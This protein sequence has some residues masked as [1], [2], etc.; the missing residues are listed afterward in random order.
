MSISTASPARRWLPTFPARATRDPIG[1]EIA[2]NMLRIAR[3]ERR[4]AHVAWTMREVALKPE[5]LDASPAA[6]HRLHGIAR[7]HALPRGHAVATLA[8]PVVDVFPIMLSRDD[9]TPLDLQVVNHAREQLNY[10]LADAVL[11]Y[12]LL[13]DAVCRKGE[14]TLAALVFCA[15][16]SVV[17]CWVDRLAQLGLEAQRL[18]TPAGA[19]APWAQHPQVDARLLIVTTAEETISIGVV[20]QGAV[21]ME[22]ILPWGSRQWVD[23]LRAELELSEPQCRA[24]LEQAGSQPALQDILG[25][26]YAELAHEADGCLAY[27]DSYLQPAAAA[28]VVLVGTMA[29]HVALQRFLEQELQLPVRCGAEGVRLPD[30]AGLAPGTVHATAAACACWQ[31][32]PTP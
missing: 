21:L 30:L 14:A 32:E 15:P 7:A 26:M 5:D 31:A 22:R 19:L 1:V 20:Q 10:P 3:A 29:G 12:A 27:C 2:G 24:L 6:N 4:G 11:D 18:M 28:G 25:P 23:R 8:S 9:T 13:P 16:R 17:E